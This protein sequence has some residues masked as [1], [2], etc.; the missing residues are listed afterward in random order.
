MRRRGLILALA[1]LMAGLLACSVHYAL[2][3]QP[4]TLRQARRGTISEGFSESEAHHAISPATDWGGR[5]PG[6][7]TLDPANNPHI[8]NTDLIV[9]AGVTL[10]IRAGVELYFAPG[11]ALIVYGR[12]LAEGTATERIL[13]TR[14][15]GGTYWGA[16]AIL[17]SSADNRIAH[18]VIEYTS[19]REG[20]F[21]RSHGVT[22]YGSRLTLA[23]ST[24][25]YTEGKDGAGVVATDNSTLYLLRNEIHDIGG[26]AVHPS[27][28]V[29]VI[30]GNHIYNAR[31][32]GYFY[33][34]IEISRMQPDS[35]ALV[36][37]NHIHDVSDDCLDVN[38]SW[39][40]IERN[41]IHHCA[42]KGISLGSG[43]GALPGS[44]TP[45]ATV[46]NNLVYASEVGVAVKDG[47]VAGLVHNTI[48]DNGT[49]LALH[50]AHDH[51]GLG[52]GQGTVVN[53]II[54]GNGQN[55]AL[56]GLSTVTV[57]YSDVEGGWEGEGNLNADP[58]F[59]TAEDY[60]LKEDSPAINAAREEGIAVDLDGQPRPVGGA[61]DMGAYERQQLLRLSAWPGDERVYL[62]WR[63][64]M[65]D[66]LLSSFAISYTDGSDGGST[67]SGLPTTTLA[68]TLTGLTNY[69]WYTVVVEGWDVGEE[70]LMRSNPAVA[71]P[72]DHFVYLPVVMDGFP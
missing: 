30:Q 9:P 45:A 52:G 32:G 28:G 10:T 25:R 42:D 66:P 72:T 14:R 69:V 63:V 11:A 54:W 36:L 40:V 33:E 37:D 43:G 57:T 6:D 71:M 16:I 18:A 27:G 60:H 12:L 49:G 23:D 68:F 7:T 39:V 65:N 48:A 61:P 47:T 46:V 29:A 24:V 70:A 34:G 50:E 41:R 59:E 35:P 17:Y 26:D 21:P 20:E 8:V 31:W 56:D 1:P 2:A 55:I 19:R 53:S 64:A 38:D 13:F 67:I 5:L 4:A 3:W 62:A 51:P 22:A 15:D 44:Q 58:S